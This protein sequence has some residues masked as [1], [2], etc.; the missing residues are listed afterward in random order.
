MVIGHHPSAGNFVFVQPSALSQQT[1]GFVAI[2]TELSFMHDSHVVRYR[3]VQLFLLGAELYFHEHM[4]RLRL[5]GF[6]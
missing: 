3:L 6:A 5:G 1:A 4:R 2:T